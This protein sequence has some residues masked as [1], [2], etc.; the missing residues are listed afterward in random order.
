V[1]ELQI[2]ILSLGISLTTV[3]VIPGHCGCAFVYPEVRRCRTSCHS[4]SRA[5]TMG[6]EKV[7]RHNYRLHT[8]A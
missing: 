3:G 2:T 4:G 7:A 5:A 6:S 8:S 1:A